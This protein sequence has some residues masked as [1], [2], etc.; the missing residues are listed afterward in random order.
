MKG[1][2]LMFLPE[3]LMEQVTQWFSIEANSDFSFRKESERQGS[4]RDENVIQHK[5]SQVN[6][7]H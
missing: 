1:K 5:D 7:S 4:T 3:L 2:V 6:S